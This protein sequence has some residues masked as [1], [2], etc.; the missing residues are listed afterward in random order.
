MKYLVANEG[1]TQT[2]TVIGGEGYTSIRCRSTPSLPIVWRSIVNGYK[3]MCL[4]FDKYGDVLEG[5]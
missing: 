1:D 5:Y 3:F 2:N 4:N